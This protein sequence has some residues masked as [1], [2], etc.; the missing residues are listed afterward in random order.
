MKIKILLIFSLLI[1]SFHSFA[2]EFEDLLNQ[3]DITASIAPSE[4]NQDNL[5][6]RQ[7]LNFD[8][9]LKHKEGISIDFYIRDINF[10]KGISSQLSSRVYFMDS[11]KPGYL[12]KIQTIQIYSN[13][14]G[15]QKINSVELGLTLK[16][17]NKSVSGIIKST[18]HS[19]K[20]EEINETYN[21]VGEDVQASINLNSD[22]ENLKRGDAIEFEISLSA[23][24]TS[25]ALIPELRMEEAEGVS[26]YYQT[27]EKEDRI[28]R[29]VASSKIRQ[30]VTAILDRAGEFSLKPKKITYL[31]IESSNV[32]EIVF[33]EIQLDVSG[34]YIPIRYRLFASIFA[35][36]FFILTYISFYY[37]QLIKDS[38]LQFKAR[39]KNKKELAN[40]IKTKD[41]K[42][43]LNYLYL[44]FHSYE[45]EVILP[46]IEN[47]EQRKAIQSIMASLYST[48]TISLIDDWKVLEELKVDLSNKASPVYHNDISELNA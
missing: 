45:L 12:R 39:R 9:I 2:D 11:R 17:D 1:M 20:V 43:L 25:I 13:Y 28:D 10:E 32:E 31:N 8:V 37:R 34:F 23:S 38:F 42:K 35:L 4:I 40:I 33:D 26:F 16:K 30:K 18:G 15:E 22:I 48:E 36:L 14:T 21:F 41:S 46:N 3:Y 47:L 6:V 27:L 29:G 24:A 5:Y 7:Q 19:F 44:R